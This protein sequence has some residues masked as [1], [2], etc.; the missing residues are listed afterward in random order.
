M[1]TE[2]N[3]SFLEGDQAAS[4]VIRRGL[5]DEKGCDMHCCS[6]AE[7]VEHSSNNGNGEGR[8]EGLN[9]RSNCE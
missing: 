5:G 7:T 3:G 1:I 9:N 4:E 6:N 2:N 8:C